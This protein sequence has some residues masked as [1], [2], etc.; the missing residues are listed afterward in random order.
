MLDASCVLLVFH[1]SQP[2]DYISSIAWKFSQNVMKILEQNPDIVSIPDSWLTPGKLLKVCDIKPRPSK[3]HPDCH[4]HM[5]LM[6]GFW[7]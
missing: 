1:Q 6:C 4:W 7:L 5:M 3:N 2:G